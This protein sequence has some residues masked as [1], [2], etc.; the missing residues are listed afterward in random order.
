MQMSLG[1]TLNV[2]V[3]FSVVDGRWRGRE[4][5]LDLDF[6]ISHRCKCQFCHKRFSLRVLAL[7]TVCKQMTIVAMRPWCKTGAKVVLRRSTTLIYRDTVMAATR[8]SPTQLLIG[9]HVKTNLPPSGVQPCRSSDEEVREHDERAKRS[10]AHHSNRRHGVRSLPSLS[11]GDEVKTPQQADWAEKGVVT[12]P[13]DTPRSFMVETS[14]GAVYRHNR[15]HVQATGEGDPPNQSI[16]PVPVDVSLEPGVVSDP[17]E[18]PSS[19]TPVA[20]SPGLRRSARRG[21]GQKSDRLIEM[22]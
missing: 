21:R 22:C 20:Q 5:I 4:A 14:S 11:P 15:G 12:T 1:L 10:Y 18:L 8:H 6:T 9:R 17:P 3:G 13:A 2:I 19:S 7:R 16:P